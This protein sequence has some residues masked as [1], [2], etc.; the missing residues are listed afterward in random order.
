[1]GI[2]FSVGKL[3]ERIYQNAAYHSSTVP[4][5][6]YSHIENI[7]RSLGYPFHENTSPVQVMIT[8][9]HGLDK[10]TSNERAKV[11]SLLWSNGIS[12]DYTT[13]SGLFMSLLQPLYS[14]TN[15]STSTFEWNVEMI[16]GICA[17]F[18]IPFVIIVVPHLLNSR[19]VVK[20]RATTSKSTTGEQYNHATGS[21]ELINLP[22]LPSVISERLRSKGG[23][24]IEN[25]LQESNSSSDLQLLSQSRQN[26]NIDV[27]C[28]YVMN[29][30]Y[31]DDAHKVKSDN[32]QWKNI[33]KIIKTSTQKMTNHLHHLRNPLNSS[34][35]SIPVV[36]TDLPFIVVRD[37]GSCLMLNGLSSLQSSE[38]GT[39]Y[40]Q[41]K[42]I[43][44]TLMYALDN[45]CQKSK[46]LSKGSSAD[47]DSSSDKMTLSIF[48]YSIPCDRY[49]LVTLA[50]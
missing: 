8:S 28:T 7:R 13:Q 4:S 3:L 49:D 48:L 22:S 18:K 45:Q 1:M 37:I 41:H 16:C 26:P 44:R 30:Q 47:I 2:R 24:A 19:N 35:Q 9:E 20:L 6:R 14:E 42:K 29:D 15:G 43:L 36:A 17:V 40:P 39:K 46:T 10:A 50:V 25:T 11:A 32:A 12:C 27:D 5:T 33:K 31:Y 38:V 34:G 23:S 21:D